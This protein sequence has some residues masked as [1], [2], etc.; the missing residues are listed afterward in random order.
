MMLQRESLQSLTS[1]SE[2]ELLE[3]QVADFN[4]EQGD[5]KYFDCPK[6]KN[7]GY[8]AV[9]EEG[10]MAMHFCTCKEA[11]KSARLLEVSGINDDYTLENYKAK[12]HWQQNILQSAEKCAILSLSARAERREGCG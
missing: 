1:L 12:Y 4:A 2:T 8:I 6:C 9:I 11:R 3:Q 10:T 5:L 7:K